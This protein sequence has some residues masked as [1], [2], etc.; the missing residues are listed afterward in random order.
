M[1]INYP[2]HCIKRTPLEITSFL[3][4]N[5]CNTVSKK[6]ITLIFND[7]VRVID[8]SI[9]TFFQVVGG[10]LNTVVTVIKIFISDFQNCEF[11]IFCYCL[12]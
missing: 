8:D 6:D 1:I 7:L 2:Y 9:L 4:R 5:T 11:L 10:P 12:V 3:E